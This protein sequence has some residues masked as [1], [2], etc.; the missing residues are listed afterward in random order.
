MPSCPWTSDTWRQN[1]EHWLSCQS[2]PWHCTISDKGHFLESTERITCPFK[3][4]LISCSGKWFSTRIGG[5][6]GTFQN[7]KVSL[8]G[9]CVVCM[10]LWK[11]LLSSAGT[12]PVCTVLCSQVLT[13]HWSSLHCNAKKWRAC[14]VCMGRPGMNIP[15]PVLF[16]IMQTGKKCRKKISNTSVHAMKS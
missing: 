6:E 4:T 11:R 8:S 1:H 12:Q 10:S 15:A 13:L 5:R 9:T 3:S 16:G 14:V 2:L 7:K